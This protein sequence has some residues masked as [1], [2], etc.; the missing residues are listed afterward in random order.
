MKR[1]RYERLQALFFEARDLDTG[2]RTHFLAE[3][4]GSDE[5]MRADV[6]GLLASDKSPRHRFEAVELGAVPSL[7]GVVADDLRDLAWTAVADAGG[8]DELPAWVP[9]DI[10][11]Y[12][13][14]R[15][16][17]AGGMGLVFE[18]IQDVPEHRVAIKILRPSLGAS[19]HLRRFR[20][21]AQ[22]LGRLTHP[23]IARIYG[24]GEIDSVVGPLHYFVLELVHGRPLLDW[25]NERDLGVRDKCRLM[26]EI[27]DAVHAAH[28]RSVVHRDLK[29]ANIL[30]DD[31]GHAR[32]L[33]FGVALLSDRDVHATSART[34]SGQLVGTLPYMSPEQARGDVDEIDLRTDV[35][36]L[37]CV[38]Y[39]LLCGTPA[40]DRKSSMAEVTRRIH[41]VEPRPAGEHDARLRGDL[42][43]IVAKAMAKDKEDRYASAAT[44][45]A[46]IRRYLNFEPIE[47][48][49]PSAIYQLRRFVR[50]NRTPVT[51]AA[52]A[53]L[54]VAAS[55]VATLIVVLR[56]RSTQ[57]VSDARAEDLERRHEIRAVQEAAEFVAAGV[58]RRALEFLSE[59]RPASRGWEWSFLDAACRPPT[60]TIA[61]TDGTLFYQHASRDGSRL[62]TGGIGGAL[63]VID[64]RESRVVERISVDGQIRALD[65]SAAGDRL[66]GV[67]WDADAHSGRLFIVEDG[68]AR[69][70]DERPSQN[71]WG[72]VRFAPDGRSL[73]WSWDDG[74]LAVYDVPSGTRRFRVA[75][76][77]RPGTDLV[78]TPDSK[79][80]A[81]RA[82]LGDAIRVWNA[83]T[84]ALER[85]FDAAPAWPAD[86]AIDPSGR[87][88]LDLTVDAPLR[89]WGLATGEEWEPGASVSS[90]P[91]INESV[92][93]APDASRFYVGVDDAVLVY[94]LDRRAVVDRLPTGDFRM[95]EFVLSH[96][97]SL[98][99]SR[100][101]W[102]SVLIVDTET[103]RSTPI[104][105]GLDV[106][107]DI[108]FD[109]AGEALWIVDSIGTVTA[110]DLRAGHLSFPGHDAPVMAVDFAPDAQL[111]VSGAE[112][113]SLRA[114]DQATASEVARLEDG[115]AGLLDLAV[116][117]DGARVV[118]VGDHAG[119]VWW[120]LE[121][122]A[123]G[124][125]YASDESEGWTSVVALAH[126]SFVTAGAASIASWDANAGEI[127]AR[128]RASGVNALALS[129]NGALL[130]AAGFDGSVRLYDA[131]SLEERGELAGHDGAPGCV[132]FS[133]D[134]RLVASGGFDSTV[135][136]HDVATGELTARLMTGVRPRG[137]ISV[138]AVCFS[139]NGDR[140]AAATDDGRVL[141]WQTE[142]WERVLEFT[143]HLDA[144]H[145]LRFRHDAEQLVSASADGSLG[146]WDTRRPELRI[147]AIE[148][149]ELRVANWRPRVRVLLDGGADLARVLEAL[150]ADPARNAL[151]RQLV[152]G[153]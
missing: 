106:A 105:T 120:N 24:S 131:R 135:L 19:S 114:W 113:G 88:L 126:D 20:V 23:G 3:E 103:G 15:Q 148:A 145:D 96:D 70:L 90:E 27:V 85:S 58:P 92:A 153:R 129:P 119:I 81:T 57:A 7:G 22:A 82:Y 83:E 99:A 139:P 74:T 12:R 41:D 86:I 44:F 66:A 13:V 117:G 147:D 32:V 146:I 71:P 152:L 47:A 53:A 73:A 128:V 48:R 45:A 2:D 43:T 29:P 60:R 102:S 33:D 26:A 68:E 36:S 87:F 111:I 151:L 112:D 14:V 62:L 101:D 37:G 64:T 93:F 25:A 11:P 136:V 55:V 95:R 6:E 141:L 28:L 104:P 49:P 34:L 67:D 115:P 72:A 144:I 69:Y 61:R 100:S 132:A 31:Q 109:G 42:E 140:L 8:P 17:G 98:L 142:P 10:G 21:E 38:F 138:G 52:T 116:L 121:T 80:C 40:I 150:G 79:R 107:W 35:Y 56:Q 65:I 5:Q 50:R 9:S 89:V 18:A 16:I 130:A 39:E 122:G 51:I 63:L 59:V 108:D 91:L 84:G 137:P 127:R 149:R 125:R 1:A 94:D 77:P 124:G 75:T 110:L 78:Y 76:G 30:V 54:L 133:P 134:G 97:G 123:I 118:A 46:D 4:C 143:A